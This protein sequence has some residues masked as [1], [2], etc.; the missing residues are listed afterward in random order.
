MSVTA[1]IT[2]QEAI[3]QL[4]LG[5][6][7]PT[8]DSTL[9]LYIDAF[10]KIVERHVG[11]IIDRTIVENYDGGGQSSIV[12]WNR[13]VLTVSS[14]VEDGT[15]LDPSPYTIYSAAGVMLPARRAL[16]RP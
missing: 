13:P 3:T 16:R 14:V 8:N 10:T 9:A 4:G 6:S 5:S 7:F 15:T 11:A 2:P 12:L 1:L